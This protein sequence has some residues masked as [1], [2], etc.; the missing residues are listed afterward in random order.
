MSDQPTTVTINTGLKIYEPD[1]AKFNLDEKFYYVHSRA[2]AP[3]KRVAYTNTA[4]LYKQE[5]TLIEQTAYETA[6][7]AGNHP[8][9]RAV[10]DVSK[11]RFLVQSSKA[12]PNSVTKLLET[13]YSAIITVYE[14]PRFPPDIFSEHFEQDFSDD[15]SET[16][17]HADAEDDG[18]SNADSE[19]VDERDDTQSA[20]SIF[21]KLTSGRA[22]HIVKWVRVWHEVPRTA[23]EK[24]LKTPPRRHPS[25]FKYRWTKVELY[26]YNDDFQTSLAMK[27]MSNYYANEVDTS[28]FQLYHVAV[29]MSGSEASLP[30][31]IKQV[32]DSP[33]WVTKSQTYDAVKALLKQDFNHRNGLV[34]HANK[35]YEYS[36]PEHREMVKTVQYTQGILRTLRLNANDQPVLLEGLCEQLFLP[37]MS[38]GDFINGYW[39][40]PRPTV[41]DDVYMK[42]LRET[43]RGRFVRI[44]T[45][46]GWDQHAIYEIS[47]DNAI[48]ANHEH[49]HLT[50]RHK[51]DLMLQYPTL[52][53]L[54]LGHQYRHA[55]MPAEL[56]FLEPGQS[57]TGRH[58]PSLTAQLGTLRTKLDV[59]DKKK[60]NETMFVLRYSKQ[61]RDLGALDDQLTAAFKHGVDLFFVEAGVNK[62]ADASWDRFRQ[63]LV[64]NKI[65]DGC[66]ITMGNANLEP[67]FLQYRP[68]H[69][70][71]DLWTAQL[72]RFV[73]PSPDDHTDRKTVV[74]AAVQDDKHNSH[75]YSTLKHIGDTQIGAQTF[76][77]NTKNINRNARRFGVD[78][79]TK[80]A[81][82]TVSRMRVRN[83]PAPTTHGSKDLA[84]ALHISRITVDEPM[85]AA[86][87]TA[88]GPRTLY[89]SVL[90]SRSFETSN[91]YQT[92]VE[93]LGLKD[94]QNFDPSKQFKKFIK[95]LLPSNAEGVSHHITIL[96]TGYIAVVRNAEEG[97]GIGRQ[98]EC[99]QHIDFDDHRLVCTSGNAFDKSLGGLTEQAIVADRTINGI[100]AVASRADMVNNE[101]ALLR[102]V[103]IQRVGTQKTKV[104]Y[105]T[106]DEDNSFVFDDGIKRK[107]AAKVAEQT[108]DGED[109]RS[110][111]SFFIADTGLVNPNTHTIAAH[112][113][114]SVKGDTKL[115]TLELL[116]DPLTDQKDS[117]GQP[118]PG[119][120]VDS[121]D[122]PEVEEKPEG[123]PKSKAEA[124]SPKPGRVL[125]EQSAN[126][127]GTPRSTDKKHRDSLSRVASLHE[128]PTPQSDNSLYRISSAFAGSALGISGSS[129]KENTSPSNQGPFQKP[130]RTRPHTGLQ[131]KLAAAQEGLTLQAP[132][133]KITNA[134]LLRLAKLWRDDRLGLYDT[135]WPIP[136]HLAYLAAKR[137]LFHLR[138]DKWDDEDD[139]K[140]PYSLAKVKEAVAKTLYFL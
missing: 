7:R 13:K 47:N 89:V 68:G 32:R 4:H 84:I 137:A 22:N 73:R 56:C 28:Q 15:D 64:K 12:N 139:D 8:V 117:P 69:D 24:R 82:E 2:Q 48:T 60:L 57:F 71:A 77:V 114:V 128:T 43:L 134:E 119:H 46:M 102:N 52:P 138:K 29:V 1:P 111:A 54:N 45:S 55:L 118:P 59:S 135:K 66:Q 72:R 95:T 36:N 106:L 127:R 14:G 63:S 53:C 35:F 75:I 3:A 10:I 20:A 34:L 92:D 126:L 104:S 105:V 80:S 9:Q 11:G 124:A 79:A 38:A 25:G 81:N 6:I 41:S 133:T 85:L 58:T 70:P 136:T 98:A 87:G 18:L 83:P 17:G 67:M 49:K 123:R 115:V 74:I 107:I 93:L 130:A 125:S 62:L 65:L 140:A 131:D 39:G 91:C 116:G 121:S 30:N 42:L 23:Q 40:L 132:V 44:K 120:G 100:E 76:I 61:Q 97:A 88:A 103:I 21:H 5:I 112:R 31:M 33:N 109:D 19:V 51:D 110:R 108:G 26:E 96:R 37:Q 90:S 113:Q 94:M 16:N 50:W 78:G 86:D 99:H 122:K 129:N 101:Y 27:R